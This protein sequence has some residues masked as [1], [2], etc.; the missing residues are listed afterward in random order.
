MC[1][2]TRYTAPADVLEVLR[3]P[4]RETEVLRDPFDP[5]N[6]PPGRDWANAEPTF[7]YSAQEDATR[8]DA[9]AAALVIGIGKGTMPLDPAPDYGL[10]NDYP[11]GSLSAPPRATRLQ[12]VGLVLGTGW[13]RL[14][15]R[16]EA[17]CGII[18]AALILGAVGLALSGL[19]KLVGG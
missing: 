13:N 17:S 4:K 19:S 7:D 1:N 3:E 2:K 18:V 8:R 12:Q 6:L 15:K 5:L 16:H 10:F 14:C 9:I 11:P